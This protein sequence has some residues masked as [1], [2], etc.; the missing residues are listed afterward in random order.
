[1]RP[2]R[3]SF[4]PFVLFLVAC[5]GARLAPSDVA[6]ADREEAEGGGVARYLAGEKAECATERW[7]VK[8][9]TDSNAAT[10]D[11]TPTRTTV[12]ALR[13][14]AVPGPLGLHTPRF[15]GAERTVFELRDVRVVCFKHESGSSGDGDLHI[16]VEDPSDPVVSPAADP[17][18]ARISPKQNASWTDYK[19]LIVEIPDPR[20]LRAGN[21][22]KKHIAR[23]RAEFEARY[24]ATESPRRV[25][26]VVSLRGIGF[27]DKIHGQLGVVPNGIELHPLLSVKFISG[28]SCT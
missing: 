13:A 12:G 11:L 3:S 18:C 27:F 16:V 2:R 15:E 19:T 7:D 22:W 17:K 24:S 20:C 25:D 1:M 14:L 10:V 4:A 28:T 8:I 9:G 5:G 21:P 23:A 6:A 26:D